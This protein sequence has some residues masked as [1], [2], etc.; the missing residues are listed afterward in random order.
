MI[1]KQSHTVLDL[2][3][4]VRLSDYVVG[5]FSVLPSKAGMR[6][7]I[8][9]GMVLVNG[10]TGNTGLY[11]HGGE[12][13]DLFEEDE[14][15]NP[16]PDLKLNVLYEDDHLAVISKPAG[17]LVSGNKLKTIDNALP[18]ALEKSQLEDA[19]TLPRPAH[20]LDFATSGL[21]LIGKTQSTLTALNKQFEN[22]E[23]HKTYYAVTVG[24]MNLKGIINSTIEN[25]QALTRYTLIQSEP[26]KNYQKINL[27]EVQPES[28]RKHQI[29]I[30]L[31]KINHPIIGDT[32][33]G[34]ETESI[35]QGLYLHA[36]KLEFVH[37]T[38]KEPMIIT[39]D[40]PKK[41][42]RLFKLNTSQ[43]SE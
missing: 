10:K 12:R 23:I 26:S 24:L 37:P 28:G 14:P 40:L 42:K 9:K 43:L 31:A 19:L 3:N 33:Y 4:P 34:Y 32:K 36:G 13:I 15:L 27:L 16:K 2:S 5:I 1:L 30:H 18:Y 35:G 21:L 25:K 29:R 22:R 6:K 20:R 7:A 8:K 38:T 17:V 41:F 11:L 39:D